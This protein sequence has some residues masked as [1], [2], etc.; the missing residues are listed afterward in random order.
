MLQGGKIMHYY[1]VLL[2]CS[3]V[4]LHRISIINCTG[5]NQN[6]FC[7]FSITFVKAS[8]PS[9]CS[10]GPK[11]PT[12]CRSF[13]SQARIFCFNTPVPCPCKMKTTDRLLITALLKAAIHNCLDSSK[14]L[15][16]LNLLRKVAVRYI[17]MK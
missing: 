11:L 10:A 7:F 12:H 14:F 15:P 16:E 5:T 2:S 6:K 13:L 9:T 17:N 4:C 1:N 8:P 3:L